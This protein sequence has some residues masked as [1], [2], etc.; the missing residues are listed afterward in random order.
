MDNAPS[1][2]K[3]RRRAFTLTEKLRIVNLLAT[4]MGPTAIA[5]EYN[6]NESSIRH[7]RKQE[8]AIRA[9]A[10]SV[11]PTMAAG[12]LRTRALRFVKTEACL[13]VWFDDLRAK[14]LPVWY[15]KVRTKA[16]QLFEL[17]RQGGASADEGGFYASNGWFERLKRK[18]QLLELRPHQDRAPP[19]EI[20]FKQSFLSM[21]E[22]RGFTRDQIFSVE[23]TPFWWKQLPGL[24]G[25]EK[26]TLIFC[27]NASGD[28][29]V[30]PILLNADFSQSVNPVESSFLQQDRAGSITEQDLNSWFS[31]ICVPEVQNYLRRKRLLVQAVLVLAH[32]HNFSPK[33]QNQAIDVVTLPADCNS[34]CL[35]AAQGI[36]THLRAVYMKQVCQKLTR[37]VNSGKSLEESWNLFSITDGIVALERSIH[38][39]HKSVLRNGWVN[40]LDTEPEQYFNAGI[41]S[42]IVNLLQKLG[43]SQMTQEDILEQITPR[44][45]TN[46]EILKIFHRLQEDQERESSIIP[47]SN[48]AE[49]IVEMREE[50]VEQIDPAERHA[51]I[52][53]IEEH[54]AALA[55][56][57]HFFEGLDKNRMRARGITKRLQQ[58]ASLAMEMRH[59]LM[60]EQNSLDIEI[61]E[62]V[63]ELDSDDDPLQ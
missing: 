48:V 15:T 53:Q 19:S 32:N 42:D 13:M 16:L 2:S 56:A 47:S 10:N 49:E 14:R 22:D 46:E 6:V 25:A 9:N 31:D 21:V 41:V 37:E 45:L 50:S 35:P 60:P 23:N 3:R 63:I 34:S 5:R 1:S 11:T 62:E 7:M 33:L 18:Y 28:F 51:L 43:L 12:S 54:L 52:G 55:N 38:F 39:L 8:A 4:G 44:E 36:L 61:K 58:V 57:Q 24:N 17:V 29:V 59:E 20:E 26:S 27:S 40:L 30:K